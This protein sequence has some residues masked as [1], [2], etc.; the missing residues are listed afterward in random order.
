MIV[1]GAIIYVGQEAAARETIVYAIACPAIYQAFSLGANE[2]NRTNCGENNEHDE[3]AVVLGPPPQRMQHA[4]GTGQRTPIGWIN[5]CNAIAWLAL[6]CRAF[7]S[8][9]CDR[10]LFIHSMCTALFFLF[11]GVLC[12]VYF[13]TREQTEEIYYKFLSSLACILV[14]PVIHVLALSAK[15][16]NSDSGTGSKSPQEAH[17]SNEESLK[18]SIYIFLFSFVILAV[19]YAKLICYDKIRVSGQS[20]HT[21]IGDHQMV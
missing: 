7:W 13:S 19:V 9:P 17:T 10:P 20:P 15:S 21:A 18:E 16:I 2:L 4:N 8:E 14:V 5:L 11:L 6:A 12:H 1:I 3:Y